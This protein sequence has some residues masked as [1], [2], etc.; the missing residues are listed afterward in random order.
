MGGYVEVGIGGGLC[1]L[2][3]CALMLLPRHRSTVRYVSY[4][5]TVI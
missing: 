5:G 1:T 3:S 2:E 4:L